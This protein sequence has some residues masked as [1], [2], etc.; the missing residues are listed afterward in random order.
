MSGA[1]STRR[2]A[3][4]RRRGRQAAAWRLRGRARRRIEHPARGARHHNAARPARHHAAPRG[5]P[6]G[7]ARRHHAR[8]HAVLGDGLRGADARLRVPVAVAADARDRQHREYR[9]QPHRHRA[10]SRPLRA[11]GLGPR[12]RRVFWS[13]SMFDILGLSP[14]NKLL[15]FGE[16]SGLVHPDDVQLYELATQLAD[17]EGS[18]IDRVFRMRHARGNWVW[19]RARCELVRQADEPHAAPDR[20]RGRHHRAEAAGGG[21]RDRRDAPLRRD[22]GDLRGVRGVGFEQ[23][24]GPVQ[25]QVPEPARADRRGVAARHAL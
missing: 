13:H 17:S 14:H 3:A 12:E 4:I 16:I 23:P 10:Q 21:K 9:A 6:V 20:D 18:S 7:V 25:F 11:V 5:R 19:L 22:R 15:G 2:S 1:S 8:R 24:A